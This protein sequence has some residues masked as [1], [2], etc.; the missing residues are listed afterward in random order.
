M[1]VWVVKVVGRPD[2]GGADVKNLCCK[3]IREKC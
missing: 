3:A 1:V 2:L